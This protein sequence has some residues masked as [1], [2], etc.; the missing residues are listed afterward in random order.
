MT[1]T[2]G[3]EA[4]TSAEN[5]PTWLAGFKADYETIFVEG[6]SPYLGSVL[7]VV[8]IAGLMISGLFWGVFGGLRLWGD[9][10]NSAIG[11][12]GILKIDAALESPLAHRM[13]LMDITLLMG[14]FAA[15]LM[16]R[17]FRIDHPPKLEYVWGA[18]GG[19][20]MG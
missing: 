7:L 11:L 19:T 3:Y 12:G 6:W 8:A 4:N 20:L 1:T 2:I 16:S 18:L 15:A 17:Q 5:A 13:S 14:A 10:F 9:W